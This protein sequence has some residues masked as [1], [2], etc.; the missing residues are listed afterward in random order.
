[1]D[2]ATYLASMTLLAR[3]DAPGS[4]VPPITVR[5][6]AIPRRPGE[7][8]EASR[9]TA[10][11]WQR[12]R[13]FASDTLSAFAAA[14]AEPVPACLYGIRG[15]QIGGDRCHERAQRPFLLRTLH[16]PV[17]L[18]GM[19]FAV[20]GLAGLAGSVVA[21]RLARRGGPAAA[22]R[23]RLRRD[24]GQRAAAAAG[25]G[26]AA[27]RRVV[28]FAVLG[29]SLPVLCGAI[30]NIG[31]TQELFMNS[32]PEDMLGR[33]IANLRSM[34]TGAQLLGALGG[35]FAGVLL[36][37]RPAVWLCMGIGLAGGLF[38]IPAVRAP[39]AVAPPTSSP[40]AADDGGE[41]LRAWASWRTRE[42]G[43]RNGPCDRRCWPPDGRPAGAHRGERRSPGP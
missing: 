16:M 42:Q 13:S 10:G 34:S 5:P 3:I 22:D 33:A 17:P 1:M 8:G 7:P 4:A 9:A 43:I 24:R 38:L 36:N 27:G 20:T 14:A 25:G 31:L 30:S 26:A 41:Q 29:I 19:L 6:T 12:A 23:S 15:G 37:V 35:G 32:V 39:G 18:Y 21:P 11:G 40:A 2:A 28:L